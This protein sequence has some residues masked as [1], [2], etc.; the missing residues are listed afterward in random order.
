MI[1]LLTF[2][3]LYKGLGTIVGPIIVG[4]YV[5]GENGNS[6]TNTTSSNSTDTW[7][8]EERKDQLK[9]PFGLTGAVQAVGKNSFCRILFS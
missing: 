4:P 9:F 6:T 8:P 7:T 2:V 3:S 5:H 1:L